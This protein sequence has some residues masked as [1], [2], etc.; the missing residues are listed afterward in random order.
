[1]KF[2]GI[3][4]TAILLTTL[5]AGCASCSK[6]DDAG[7]GS[8]KVAVTAYATL[9]GC[10]V[11]GGKSEF[12]TF[13]STSRARLAVVGKSAAYSATV[14]DAPSGMFSFTGVE[15]PLTRDNTLL[16]W[17]SFG[18]ATVSYNGSLKYTVPTSQTGELSDHI[19]YGTANYSSGSAGSKFT[20]KEACC[21]MYV[22]LKQGGYSVS[23]LTIKSGGGELIAG[24]VTLDPATESFSATSSEVSVKLAE[25]VSCA[26]EAKY[27]A[28]AL[29]P[30][31]LSKGYTITLE[32]SD[33]I[34]TVSSSDA[35][36][37]KAGE[38]VYTETV[39][40][41]SVR[42]LMA[43]GS[44]KVYLFDATKADW[45]GSYKSGLLWS[46]DC[47][48]IQGTVSG[49]KSSSHI[50]DVVL[51]NNRKQILVT[52]SNNSG[53]CVL[54]EP[55]YS[56]SGSADLLFWT[57]KAT[58]AHSAEYLPGGY[59]AVACSTDGGDCL[60]LYKVGQNNTPLST[61]ALTSAHGCVWNEESQ[62]LYAIGGTSLQIYTW[63]SSEG[64]LTLEKT[65][66]T[67]GFVSG[68]H[69]LSL[70][71]A[72]TLILGGK[73][74]ATYTISTGKFTSLAWFNA[75]ATNGIKSL[76]YN[77]ETQ[78]IF[79]TFAVSGTAE[80]SYDWSSHKIRYTSTPASAYN[81][82]NEKHYIVDD[83]NMYKVRVYNW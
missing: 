42:K 63:N 69:D 29:A 82:G 41:D 76:N 43:C 15:G 31:T 47:T 30:A 16:M 26:L 58:N 73:N 64:K 60:Q 49:C 25:A 14:L 12:P 13:G 22:A 37:L 44:N 80:G 68:L 27:I 52:C 71:D 19:M 35:L 62:R 38:C 36:Q 51:V 46:W 54:L 9:K 48:S 55:D 70:V 81:A 72:N 67:S 50:D 2:H 21:V 33:G 40:P 57:N 77:P 11:A 83:I 66:S 28:V 10:Y 45:E 24:E 6:S 78:E 3:F 5:W 1:M 17:T 8:S 4:S 59:V 75:T 32:T 79:Y 34:K 53:W 39:N 7:T 74:A 56:T 23:G 65:V 18:Q 61:Y 20:L